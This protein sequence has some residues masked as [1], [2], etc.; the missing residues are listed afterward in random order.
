MKTYRK[1]KFVERESYKHK[2]AKQI[3][4][5]WCK[6]DEWGGERKCVDTNFSYENGEIV[7]LH[8]KPNRVEGAC[9]EYP[10]TSKSDIESLWDEMWNEWDCS[11]PTY[12]ECIKMGKVPICIIDVVLPS[13]GLPYY[14]IE[15]FH[16]NPV[17]DSKIEKLKDLGMHNL[18]EIDADWILSQISVPNVLKI[19]RW[20]I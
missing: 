2:Y 15:I 6:S 16:K 13:L 9:L 11:T 4:K 7:K 18:I 10:I 20:L 3:F 1:K 19:K 8:W 12:D 14:F 17:S 5:E